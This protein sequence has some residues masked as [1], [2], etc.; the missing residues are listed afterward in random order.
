MTALEP[1]VDPIIDR[2]L[3]LPPDLR[4]ALVSVLDAAE[5]LQHRCEVDG[6]RP[7][8][9][10]LLHTVFVRSVMEF[11][12]EAPTSMQLPESLIHHLLPSPQAI[13]L[14]SVDTDLEVPLGGTLDQRRSQRSFSNQPLTLQEV[15]NLLYWAVG[16]RGT[17]AGYGVRGVPLFRYPSIGG[18][19]ALE[20]QLVAHA[21]EGLP[22]GRY[23]YDAVGHGLVPIDLG[24]M[25]VLLDEVT[26]DAEW[27]F[28][29]PAVIACLHDQ[30][31]I[32]WKY[33]TRGYR[34]SHIDL[35]TALQNLYLTATA[36]D[37]GGCAVAGFF[38]AEAN[39]LLGLDGQ[40]R[41]LSL[42]FACGHLPQ[43]RG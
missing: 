8:L 2:L 33:R 25:R 14:P 41:F 17:E 19:A 26:F 15:A 36:L 34:F 43:P 39:D 24:D 32:A 31:K 20:F 29:A 35:G 16:T 21:V 10:R 11:F 40:D 37:L 12:T 9:R 38:D 28:H 1:T 3:A 42:L 5:D 18:L 30:G 13:A 4:G 27:L 23:R 6:G 22:Q 7:D